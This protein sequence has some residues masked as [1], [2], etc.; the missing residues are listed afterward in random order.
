MSPVS[1]RLT[2]AVTTSPIRSLY[3][4]WTFS[5]SASRA[6]CEST[7]L[8]VCA[9]MRVSTGGFGNSIS[10]STSASSPYICLA[11]VSEISVAGLVDLVDDVLDRE[12]FDHAGL[13]VEA[14]AEILGGLVGLARGGEHGL[15]E[16][17]DDHLGLDAPLLGHGFDQR[18]QIRHAF[19]R[20]SSAGNPQNS[21][22]SRPRAM[23]SNGRRTSLRLPASSTTASS[24]TP[25]SR[26][27]KCI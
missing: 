12:D 7:C 2:A 27:S 8:T 17:G 1:K 22:A 21:T 3:S 9:A 26:P 5:R 6:F 4:S 20:T 23:L 25:H 24:S 19:F 14:R 10:M 11:S 13:G 15:F 18:K 16:R